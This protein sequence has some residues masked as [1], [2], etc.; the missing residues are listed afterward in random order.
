MEV[1]WA[2]GHQAVEAAMKDGHLLAESVAEARSGSFA[3]Q[4]NMLKPKID[5]DV[6]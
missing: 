3:L 1:N 2:L 6:T 4:S 5:P